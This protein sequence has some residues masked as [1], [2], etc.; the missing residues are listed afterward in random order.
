MVIRWNDGAIVQTTVQLGEHAPFP[1][2]TFTLLYRRHGIRI[3]YKMGQYAAFTT[4]CWALDRSLFPQCMSVQS[5]IEAGSGCY[6]STS[7]TVG[8]SNLFH[9]HAHPQSEKPSTSLS[10]FLHFLFHKEWKIP[11]IHKLHIIFTSMLQ[12]SFK[13]TSSE[14]SFQLVLIYLASL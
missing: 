11:D 7:N 9:L 8:T 1:A 14:A 5:Y 13:S 12:V 6:S 10:W 2:F 3:K 4:L